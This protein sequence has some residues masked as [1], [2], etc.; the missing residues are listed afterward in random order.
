MT[1]CRS[2]ALATAAAAVFVIHAQAQSTGSQNQQ[3]QQ[4]ANNEQQ[5]FRF[6]TGV[7]LINVTA[8]VT[9]E[10]GRF[11]SGLQQRRLP[12]LPGRPAAADHPLQQRARAGQPRHRARHERQHGRR[13]D[14][15]RA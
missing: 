14:G 10:T 13:E 8:T 4:P 11:V 15:C 7:E 12:R 6:K 5:A 1:R 2:L 3:S 9:D